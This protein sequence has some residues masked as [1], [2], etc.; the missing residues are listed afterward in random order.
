T[1]SLRRLVEKDTGRVLDRLRK[2][3]EGRV[4]A[5]DFLFLA[6][7]VAESGDEKLRRRLVPV[8][9][10]QQR[11]QQRG[12]AVHVGRL[13]NGEEV[14]LLQGVFSPDGL[15]LLAQ[16]GEKTGGVRFFHGRLG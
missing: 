9:L 6:H 8:E 7:L 3:F 11:G 16:G 12:E 2:I 5:R 1:K 4:Q 10:L 13:R 15:Q 14:I